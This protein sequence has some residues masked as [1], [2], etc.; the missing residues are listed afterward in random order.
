VITKAEKTAEI[1]ITDVGPIHDVTIPIAPGRIVKLVGPNGAGKSTAIGAITGAVQKKNPGLTPR[2]GRMSGKL[3]MPGVTVTFGARMQRKET[4]ELPVTFAIVEDGA[5]I[6]KILDPG[7]KD[8]E[9]AD[10][11]RLEGVLDVIGATLTVE[12]M[13]EFLGNELFGKFLKTRSIKDKGFVGAVKEMKLFL[14]A[15]AREY[16]LIVTKCDGAIGEIGVLAEPVKVD[17]TA[18]ELS[19]EIDSLAIA[20]RDAA[21]DREKAQ[22]ALA[23]IDANRSFDTTA[24]ESQLAAVNSVVATLHGEE[25]SLQQQIAELQS[26]LASCQEKLRRECESRSFIEEQIRITKEASQQ[27]QKLREQVASAPSDESIKE[28]QSRLDDLRTQHAQAIRGEDAVRHYED[29][30]RRL[31]DLDVQRQGALSRQQRVKAKAESTGQLLV[32]ALKVVP[33]WSVDDEYRLCVEH[34]RGTIR[35][36]DLSPGEGTARACLLA[37]Q[38]AEFGPDE[39]PIVGLPQHCFEGLDGKNRQKLQEVAEEHGLCILTAECDTNPDAP[40][41]LRV[42]LM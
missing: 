1:S 6:E 22:Q 19:R 10:R 23:A 29:A 2:D 13:Q 35:F 40:D 38:F 33:G 27:M 30:K 18:A 31:Q 42:E 37:C 5:G 32:E 26:R 20:V 34:K 28:Q 7:F 12:Q 21:R 41:E 8:P 14:E 11:R 4:G 36:S 24:V 16:G 15:E 3:R 39:I 9:A 25:S 17:R